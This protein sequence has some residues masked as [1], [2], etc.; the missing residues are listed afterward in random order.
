MEYAADEYFFSLLQF[1]PP[2]SDFPSS[3]FIDFVDEF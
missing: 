1:C 2:P 3:Q